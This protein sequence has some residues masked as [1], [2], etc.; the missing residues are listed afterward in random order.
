[1]EIR[2]AA[3]EDIEQIVRLEQECFPPAEAAGEQAFRVRLSVFPEHFWLLFDEDTLVSMVN[4]MVTDEA[5]LRDEMYESAKLHNEEGRWQMI[6][7]VTT[8]PAYRRQGLAEQVLRQAISDAK[9]QGR[10]GLVLTCKERLLPYY[11]KFGFINE[12]IS[13]SAHGNVQWYQMRLKF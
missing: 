7:G 3:I 9:E 8:A 10:A 1:M 2:H 11:A 4:G 13:G 5:D 12:G 6:F